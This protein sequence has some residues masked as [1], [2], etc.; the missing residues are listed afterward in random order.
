[1][2]A[3][4]F[5]TTSGLS[6]GDTMP[7]YTDK[8]LNELRQELIDNF[9][10]EDLEEMVNYKDDDALRDWAYENDQYALAEQYDQAE[11]WLSCLNDF[12]EYVT[13]RDLTGAVDVGEWLKVGLQDGYNDGFQLFLDNSGKLSTDDFL[14]GACEEDEELSQYDRAEMMKFCNDLESAVNFAL[15]DIAKME[16]WGVTSGGFTGGVNKDCV[17]D[18][19]TE[20]KALV[21]ERLRQ[22]WELWKK[23]MMNKYGLH[24]W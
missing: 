21:S 12:I 1:M 14:D 16:L 3:C 17:D 24:V 18:V 8:E 20:Q 11:K 10:V 15:V 23:D 19:H 4:N 22:D 9:G 2:G 13:D 7:V 5:M 6:V